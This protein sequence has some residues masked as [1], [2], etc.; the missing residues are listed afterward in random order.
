MMWMVDGEKEGYDVKRWDYETGWFGE[1]C[2]QNVES[3]FGL[4]DVNELQLWGW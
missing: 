3:L 4:Y 2:F 1:L